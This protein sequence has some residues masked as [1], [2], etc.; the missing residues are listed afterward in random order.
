MPAAVLPLPR[1][2]APAILVPPLGLCTCSCIL[3][4]PLI[5]SPWLFFNHPPWFSKSSVL[6]SPGDRVPPH[7]ILT[8]PVSLLLC[9]RDHW[10]PVASSRDSWVA[11]HLQDGLPWCCQVLATRGQENA[12]CVPGMALYL[13]NELDLL[14]VLGKCH[15]LSVFLTMKCSGSRF[16]YFCGMLLGLAVS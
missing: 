6:Q 13:G 15:S 11:A 1:S 2:S 8:T 9:D 14:C 16:W 3:E 5:P 7:W 12:G 4:T 10:P